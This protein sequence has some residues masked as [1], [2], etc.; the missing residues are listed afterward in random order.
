MRRFSRSF[1]V[2]ILA[3]AILRCA[4]AQPDLH[5]VP[6]EIN[7]F[8]FD[9]NS[10]PLTYADFRTY[11]NGN[12]ELRFWEPG[13]YI[14]GPDASQFEVASFSLLDPVQ[15]GS[16]RTDRI[17][18]R[19]NSRGTK[20]AVLNINTNDP[21]EF[22]STIPLMGV[23]AFPEL[24][25]SPPSYN[26]GNRS[27][28]DGATTLSIILTSVG[29]LPLEFTT[30]GIELVS[31][32]SFSLVDMPTTSTMEPRTSRT[33]TVAFDPFQEGQAQGTLRFHTNDPQAPVRE[34]TLQGFGTWAEIYTNPGVLEFGQKVVSDPEHHVLT[35]EISNWGTEP[36][37]FTGA[38]FSITGP[39]GGPLPPGPPQF[40]LMD[41]PSTAPIAALQ[42]ASR[43]VRIGFKPTSLG[44]KTA[45]LRITTNDPNQPAK[46]VFLIGEG[47]PAR[48]A[49]FV[50]PYNG[51]GPGR[52][53]I[54]T[55]GTYASLYDACEAVS[56]VGSL[57]GGDWN[58]LI[59]NNLT[60]VKNSSL[61]NGN[62]GGHNIIFR[63]APA[64]SST[65]SFTQLNA[66]TFSFPGHFI[67]GAR[68]SSAGTGSWV[69][70]GTPNV[71]IDGSNDPTTNTRNLT[72][73]NPNRLG[74]TTSMIHVAGDC[75]NTAIQN[76][77]FYHTNGFHSS[78]DGGM[79]AVEFFGERTSPLAQLRL[80]SASADDAVVRNCR[81]VIDGQNEAPAITL[82]YRAQ[83]F[84]NYAV[85]PPSRGIRIE[86]NDITT[87][88]TAIY[89]RDC[90]D[91]LVRHNRIRL[92]PSY[93]GFRSQAGIVLSNFTSMVFDR[94]TTASAIVDANLVQFAGN[95]TSSNPQT[96]IVISSRNTT[97]TVVVSNNMISGLTSPA[98]FQNQ[99]GGRRVAVSNETDEGTTA[100][101]AHNSINFHQLEGT[102]NTLAGC[103]AFDHTVI[104][105]FFGGYSFIHNNIVRME[106]EGGVIFRRLPGDGVI[107][108][109]NN[110][111]HTGFGAHI[112]QLAGSQTPQLFTF[113]SDWQQATGNDL[114]S[115][116]MDPMF[117]T[118][119]D[120]PAVWIGP[121]GSPNPDMHFTHF[122]GSGL[123]RPPIPGITIDFDGEPRYSWETMIGADEVDESTSVNDWAI[124]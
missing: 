56:A 7:L 83:S 101:I 64:T 106:P 33:L 30:S 72:F 45:N 67:I 48:Q 108:S 88:H 96:G 95:V 109:D 102:T 92:E 118:G 73:V 97:S 68:Y 124:Y 85:D 94:A 10:T 89:V 114:N 6:P 53:T 82:N 26:F 52:S 65:V 34:V 22:T 122:P 91:A 28:N 115:I 123:R 18:F 32:G 77:H 84:S 8:K 76:C 90:D 93:V 62:T 20:H 1:F 23:A 107:D 3:A 70:R 98:S 116:V 110:G 37:Q 17:I 15:P 112:G 111:L 74:G 24:N 12:Q 121:Y 14:T 9:V 19:P 80:I 61:T 43:K 79:G 25:L 13:W 47:I 21:D 86:Q 51:Y 100:I 59:L 60:E 71:V 69:Y 103:V 42:Q 58:F 119:M 46:S 44:Q 99:S 75:D 55:G 27:V 66:N 2:I 63:P 4:S 31:N 120:N 104:N 113:I 105:Q 54:G 41:V 36:L 38:G 78:V 39:G 29:A 35:V 57:T 87:S 11:N 81:F 40:K 50:G 5:V 16:F 117:A 49:T